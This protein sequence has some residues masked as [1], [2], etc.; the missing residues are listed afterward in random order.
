VKVDT[1]WSD[2]LIEKGVRDPL[3][4]W[5]VGGR[6]VRDLLE[7]FTTVIVNR[8]AR[9]LSMYCWVFDTLNA[10]KPNE[11]KVQFW[12]RFFRLEAILLC[13]IH[14]HKEHAYEGFGGEIGSENASELL[15]KSDAGMLDLTKF[16]KIKNAWETNYYGPMRQLGLIQVNPGL[17]SGINLTDVGRD[18]AKAYGRSISE[19]EFFK[20]Y[21]TQEVVVRRRSVLDQR[22]PLLRDRF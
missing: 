12:R 3:G 1:G 20:T 18:L 19:T 13:A 22:R 2:L 17:P 11:K 14:C 4:V 21:K 15:R 5:R 9:Y 10:D 6:M 16:T 8:P 7:P